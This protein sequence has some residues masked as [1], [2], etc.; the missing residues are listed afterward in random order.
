[1][2]SG[3]VLVASTSILLLFVAAS[4]N[5]HNITH[6][7]AGHPSLSTFNHYLTVTHLAAEINRRQTITVLAVDN[8][9]MSALLSKQLSVETIK[10]VLSLHVLVDYFGAKKLH[11]ITGGSTLTASIFQATGSAP[12]TSGFV[13]ITD[14]K[15]GRVG[16]GTQ[17][18]KLNAFFVKSV[19]EMP[20]NISVQQISQLLNSDQA[21]APASAPSVNLTAAMN[22]DCKAFA[23]LLTATKVDTTF[24][25]NVDGGLTVFCPTDS[26]VKGFMSKYSKLTAVQKEALLLF[27]GVPI[28]QSLQMLKSNN[29]KVNTLAT[30]GDG[31]YQLTVQNDGEVIK[32][33][34]KIATSK[35]TGTLVAE[36]PLAIYKIDKFLQP[37]EIFDPTSSPAPKSSSSDDGD[38]DSPNGE[39]SDDENGALGRGVGSL[40]VAFSLCFGLLFV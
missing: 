22:K 35:I 39:P 6:I 1:M 34:T 28:F 31:K 3:L 37:A 9:A 16:F 17:D 25:D 8:S 2:A 15:A 12:G 19:F 11:Q 14:L 30:D 20:Y 36:D 40:I 18:G 26:V 4:T 32:L 27:H 23:D 21:E 10:N 29:G 33:Q 24:N 5:A 38:A 7:L 13:N